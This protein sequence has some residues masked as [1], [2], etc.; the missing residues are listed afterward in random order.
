M[1]MSTAFKNKNLKGTSF[2]QSILREADFSGANLESASFFDAD[3]SFADFTGANMRSANLEL[4]NLRGAT[5]KDVDLTGAYVVGN[6]KIDGVVIDGADFTDV[7]WRKDQQRYLCSIAKGVNPKTGV[8]TKES[9]M[10][11]E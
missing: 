9:L 10:C 11:P 1:S 7:L 3:V 4:A 5:F 2:Q 8:E 6:T